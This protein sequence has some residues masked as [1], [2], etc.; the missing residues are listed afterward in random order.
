MFPLDSCWYI[1]VRGLCMCPTMIMIR[2]NVCSEHVWL[3]VPVVNP[4]G[5]CSHGYTGVQVKKGDT[6]YQWACIY[7]IN[8]LL[9]M[10]QLG[11]SSWFIIQSCTSCNNWSATQPSTL[12]PYASHWASSINQP[13]SSKSS[14]ECHSRDQLLIIMAILG[15]LTFNTSVGRF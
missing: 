6:Y 4:M 2:Q 7:H 9:Y 8:N 12:L 10:Q 5:I 1:Q 13:E 15:L 11:Y 3:P 14:S